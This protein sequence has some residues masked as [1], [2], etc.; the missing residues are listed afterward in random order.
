MKYFAGAAPFPPP[1]GGGGSGST[2]RRRPRPQQAASG[3]VRWWPTGATLQHLLSLLVTP[4]TACVK[5]VRRALRPDP[6]SSSALSATCASW[7]SYVCRRRRQQQQQQPPQPHATVVL[8]SEAELQA[9][10]QARRRRAYLF[11]AAHWGG[12]LL[13]NILFVVDPRFRELVEACL[14]VFYSSAV[15]AMGFYA[16]VAL[17]NPGYLPLHFP[18]HSHKKTED[19]D[20]NKQE[21]L[22]EGRYPPQ[23]PQK[24]PR[25]RTASAAGD[26]GPIEEEEEEEEEE[27]CAYLRIHQDEKEAEAAAAE[28]S[29]SLL[30]EVVEATTTTT[31]TT[32]ANDEASHQH[33]VDVRDWLRRRYCT[34]CRVHRLPLRTQHC[35][36]CGR[37]VSRMDHHCAWVGNCVGAGNHLAFVLFLLF[38]WVHVTLALV[39]LLVLGVPTLL[40]HYN[41]THGSLGVVGGVAQILFLAAPQAICERPYRSTLFLLVCVLWVLVHKALL[42]QLKV[43]AKN[44]LTVEAADQSPTSSSVLAGRNNPFDKGCILNLLSFLSLFYQ[45]HQE[46]RIK[47][48][49]EKQRQ[50]LNERPTPLL[51]ATSSSSSSSSSGASSSLSSTP[52]SLHGSPAI[53]SSSPADLPA[54][55]MASSSSSTSAFTSLSAVGGGVATTSSSSFFTFFKR[56]FP[57][58]SASSSTSLET[59]HPPAAFSTFSLFRSKKGRGALPMKIAP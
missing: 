39:L 3:R 57:S 13:L 22:E 25:A 6:A 15:M 4:G 55:S 18:V 7:S 45:Y 53:S 33:G 43:V 37:C 11:V 16:V 8:P 27:L 35:H 20:D 14:D 36:S 31:T 47:E 44:R 34:P 51:S 17:S 58:S 42:Q 32:V 41:F 2:T 1:P 23:P 9:W 19:A 10:G 56:K 29:D 52:S 12:M 26:L 38:Q 40:S 48:R 24:E 5:T 21:L 54:A 59:S 28:E 49:R 46:R 50:A 30:L